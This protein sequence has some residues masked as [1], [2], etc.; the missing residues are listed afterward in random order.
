MPAVSSTNSLRLAQRFHRVRDLPVF[1]LAD[2]PAHQPVHVDLRFRCEHAHEQRLFR[3]F[4]R[5]EAGHAAV[6]GD[7]LADVEHQAGLAHRRA[8]RDDDQ[9]AGL[10]AARLAIDVVEAG[11]H[12]GDEG[13]VLEQLLDLREALADQ[14]AHRHEAGLDAVF[15]DREDRALGL[16]EDQVGF[17]IGFVGGAEDLVRREDQVAERRL[18][19]DDLRVVLDVGRARHAVDERRDVGRAAHFLEVAGALELLL[20]RDEIDR[21]AA[22]RQIEHAIEDAAMR[23]AKERLRI[24][25]RRRDVEGV[26]VDQDRAEHRSLRF[27][28][29]RKRALRGCGRGGH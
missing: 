23:V 14:R 10:Q 25:H 5:E 24:D 16:V 21:L 9:V 11:R 29:V 28:V 7:V 3:H 27:E 12:A 13:L 19:L 4:E 1:L 6:R 8:R 26:V 20:E 22:L 15:G 18:L 2:L 17:L